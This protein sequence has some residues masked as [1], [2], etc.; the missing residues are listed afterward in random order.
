M[1]MIENEQ[2]GSRK[3]EWIKNIAIIFLSIMLILTFFSNTIMNY[4]LPIVAAQYINSGSIT[5]KVRGTGTVEAGDPYN[6]E[7]A[8]TRVIKSVAVKQGDYVEKDQVLFYLEDEESEEL[9]AAEAEL[10][11]LLSDFKQALLTGG[12]SNTVIENAQN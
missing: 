1:T 12:I 6:V 5:A 2:K 4:S 11:K 10:E 3:R 9:A 8:E 7:L